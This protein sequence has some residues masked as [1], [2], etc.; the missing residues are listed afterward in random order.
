MKGLRPND[1]APIFKSLNMK[2]NINLSKNNQ[3]SYGL[4]NNSSI[5][6]I[7]YMSLKNTVSKNYD[8][9]ISFK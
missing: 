7:N 8:S 2:S 5:D 9:N 6:K 1:S 4:N 3:S